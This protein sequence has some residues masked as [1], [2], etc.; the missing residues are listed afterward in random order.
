MDPL[1]QSIIGATASQASA[2]NKHSLFIVALIGF[3]SGMAPDIDVFIRSTDD[4]LL[5]LEFHRQFTHS[6]IFIPVGGLICGSLLYFILNKIS[7]ISYKETLIYS[8]IGYGTHG[9]LDACTSY[10]TLLFWPFS[11]ERVS[12]DNISIIDPMFTIPLIIFVGL[13][14]Y[15]HKKTFVFIGLFWALFYLVLGVIFNSTA[16]DV[17]KKIAQD[18]G[19]I[20]SRI[21]AKPTFANSLLWKIIY[22]SEGIFYTDGVRVFPSKKIYYGESIKKLNINKDFSMLNKNSQQYRDIKR[23]AWFSSDYLALD[24][25]NKNRVIDIRYSMLPNQITGLWGIEIDPD[26]NNEQ[27][28]KYVTNRNLSD[29]KFKDLINMIFID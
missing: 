14:I 28:I 23:F 15:K 11:Y 1:S 19:H 22:E 13:S 17:G 10:G 2:R 6:L 7:S 18:R 26:G 12:W 3:L 9:L 24:P 5:F 16:L 20:I 21:E 29:R 8:T 4:P 27:H 25:Q